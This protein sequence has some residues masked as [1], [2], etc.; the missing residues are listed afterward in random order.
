MAANES[1]RD[2]IEGIVVWDEQPSE[3]RMAE[4]RQSLAAKVATMKRRARLSR[5]AC[6]LG[7]LMFLV[8]CEISVLLNNSIHQDLAWLPAASSGVVI[9]GAILVAVGAVGL[10]IFQ[11]F[12]YVW[13]RDDLHDAALMELSLQVQRLAQRMDAREKNA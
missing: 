10:V 4:V 2:L 13:A 9:V 5:N 11:G 3:K 6:V 8:G 1:V 7:A 12:G